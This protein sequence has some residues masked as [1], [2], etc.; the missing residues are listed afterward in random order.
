M[1]NL[2]NISDTT[3]MM[4]STEIAD[5]T[6]KQK[7]HI[8]YDIKLQLLENL[9]GIKDGQLMNHQQIQGI[10]V[11]KDNRGYW[12]EVLLDEYHYK[13]LIDKY[14]GIL[15]VP[16]R[17]QEEAS[18]KTIEQL[19]KI[20]LI[21]QYKC[22]DYRIDGYDPINNIAYEIDEYHHNNNILKDLDRQNRIEK[23][24]GC[25]FIRIKI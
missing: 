7:K 25:T 9:Y 23:V 16:N 14:N 12:S 18:L 2:M 17:L 10:T 8:H 3:K 13:L 22:L 4:S 5:L 6:G 11:V 20:T 19:L 15:R 21:R 24:L 1:N